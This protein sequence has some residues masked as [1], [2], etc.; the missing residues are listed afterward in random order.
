ME[1]K[2]VR[3]TGSYTPPRWVQLSTEKDRVVALDNRGTIW[4]F[5]YGW[6]GWE[7]LPD[8]PEK[9]EQC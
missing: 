4:E 2:D 5:R 7:Q 1:V 6:N 9:E 8:H 3:I